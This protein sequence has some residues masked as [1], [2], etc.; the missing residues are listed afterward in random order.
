MFEMI[1]ENEEHDYQFSNQRKAGIVSNVLSTTTG[2]KHQVFLTTTY[3]N[4]IL[5][6]CW[7]I[8]LQKR[9]NDYSGFSGFGT[10]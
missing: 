10:D 4:L 7:G 3:R 6:M 2:R 5:H 9:K 8:R 1:K